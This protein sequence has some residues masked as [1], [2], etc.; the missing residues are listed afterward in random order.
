MSDASQQREEDGTTGAEGPADDRAGHSLQDVLL[1]G[2]GWAS[3]GLEAADELADDLARRVGV[4]RDEMRAAMQDTFASWR[5]EA[6]RAGE[7]R[8][9]VA[10]RTLKKLGVVRRDEIDDLALRVAQLEHRTRLLEKQAD[11]TP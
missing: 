9:D 6:E 1:A 11:T 4:Q 3:L 8:T 2:I 5:R 10:D 7:R